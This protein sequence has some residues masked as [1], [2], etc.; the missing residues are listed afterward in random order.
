MT[1]EVTLQ[2]VDAR[3]EENT[4]DL[5]VKYNLVMAVLERNGLL[6]DK[7][8][9][10]PPPEY[11]EEIRTKQREIEQGLAKLNPPPDKADLIRSMQTQI[12]QLEEALPVLRNQLE[13]VARETKVKL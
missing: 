4:N 9:E 11:I 7:P 1:R 13:K 5:Q 8:G 2:D 3:L 10:K 6:D 12:Q